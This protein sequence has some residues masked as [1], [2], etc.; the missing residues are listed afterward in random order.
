MTVS[1]VQPTSIRTLKSLRHTTGRH[2]VPMLQYFLRDQTRRRSKAP[3]IMPHLPW[4]G[5]CRSMMTTAAAFP[6]KL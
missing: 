3:D 6:D 1:R 2:L 4:L 5:M